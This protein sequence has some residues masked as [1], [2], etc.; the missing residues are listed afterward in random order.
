V[1]ANPRAIVAFMRQCN[2]VDVTRRSPSYEMRLNKYASR[3]FEVY[4]P[5]LRRADIDPTVCDTSTPFGHSRTTVHYGVLVP[6]HRT[7]WDRN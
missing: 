7:E 6:E 3:G 4:V 1:W 5:S 2:T